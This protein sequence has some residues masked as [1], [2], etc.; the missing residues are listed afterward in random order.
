VVAAVVAAGAAVALLLQ[1]SR[2]PAPQPFHFPP[3]VAATPTV[4]ITAAERARL[5][6]VLYQLRDTPSDGTPVRR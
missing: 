4:E 3:S 2:P 6:Q 1:I 5:E